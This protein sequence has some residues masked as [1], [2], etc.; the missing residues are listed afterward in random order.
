MSDPRPVIEAVRD[1]QGLSQEGAD[2]IAKGLQDGSMSDAQSAAFAMAVLLRGLDRDGRI[3]L[4]KAMRDSGQV[5]TWDL[6][7]PVVDKHSTGGI[8]D[9]VSLI[10][11]PVLAA[12]G[13]FVPMISGRGLGH[14]GGTLDKLESIPGLRTSLS[15]KEFQAVTR[16]VGTAIVSANG[17]LAPADARLYA[18]RDECGAVPSLDL[19]T[20][21][22]ISKKLAAG[23]EALVLDVK[24]GSGAFAKATAE[25]RALATALVDTAEGSGCRT[26]AC[27]TDMNQPL[28]R[29]AG[30]TLE[31]RAVIDG[32]RDGK[33]ALV[34]LSLALAR[35]ALSLVGMDPSRADAALASGAA[36][37]RFSRMIAAQGGPADLVERP[38][39]YLETAPVVL[40]VPAKGVV[41]SIDGTALGHAVVALGGGR[42]RK[43]DPID[44]RVGLS[45]LLKLGEEAGPDQ[46]LAFVH[47]AD[48]AS[49][50][51]AVRA[52]QAAYQM[53]DAPA[54]HPLI[55][56]RIF[57]D[58]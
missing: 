5:M 33:G 40:P 32:F 29:A 49:A 21:S 11:G 45:G 13:V 2:L 54:P 37:E 43:A 10:L 17:D 3:A 6:P 26:M 46:P 56:E 36:V 30:N 31:V 8:G 18:I 42:V 28:A 7:G 14:T 57:L 52:V 4:T 55:I 50:E 23:P 58:A 12:C 44:P 9:P 15:G 38:D 20:A 39:A 22:I 35:E 19:V 25:A 1:G 51:R 47:A 16:S 24:C 27:L 34:D 41:T 53:G 48:R